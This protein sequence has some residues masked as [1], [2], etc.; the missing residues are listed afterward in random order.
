MNKQVNKKLTK[1]VR[2]D[3]G[4]HKILKLKATAGGESIKELLERI[5]A[6]VI[7]P[8]DLKDGSKKSN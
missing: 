1:L 8:E 7:T 4:W 2:I 5:F 6:D 3:A